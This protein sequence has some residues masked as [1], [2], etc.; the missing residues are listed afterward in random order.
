V[1]TRLTASA[2]RD[3]ATFAD[4]GDDTGDQADAGSNL[5]AIS[6]TDLTVHSQMIL[7]LRARGRITGVM[8]MLRL[9]PGHPYAEDDLA[10]FQELGD[11]AALILDNARLFE[12]ARDAVRARDEF[13]SAAA[14]ELRTPVTTVKGY[15][16]MLLRAQVKAGL[17]SDRASQFLL[18]I[19]E[20][21]DR[22]RVLTDDLVDVSRL[23]LGQM[24]LRPRPM[25]LVQLTRRLV[26][27]YETQF[28]ERHTLTLVSETEQAVVNVDPDR[29]E[30]VLTNLLENAAKYSPEGGQITI[31][32]S[33][34]RDGIQIEITDPGIGLPAAFKD[35][36]FEPFRRAE[37]AIR[38]NVPGLGLGLY[39]CANIVE[40]HGGHIDAI[41]PG[42][43]RGTTFRLWLPSEG[44]A[45]DA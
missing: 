23:R 11:R 16:Q 15:A 1:S 39:I 31:T 27:R 7:P 9:T 29:I 42:E 5:Q 44:P 35:S 36:I 17:A 21:T 34:M 6:D 30:Q 28:E 41:S 4:A 33:P 26:D 14:H 2:D 13:L 25:D 40:R 10:F 8:A 37:N 43:G 19:D 18:A 24:P 3:A 22:L 32:I 12:E 45:A 20:S 38:D